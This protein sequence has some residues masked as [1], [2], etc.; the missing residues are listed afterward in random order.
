M[1]LFKNHSLQPLYFIFNI[2]ILIEVLIC[3]YA[4]FVELL[5]SSQLLVEAGKLA[6]YK[7]RVYK[8]YE[9]VT[10]KLITPLCCPYQYSRRSH[11]HRQ[12]SD[13][14]GGGRL[15]PLTSAN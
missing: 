6:S 15:H 7:I 12:Q 10:D 2:I 3:Y 8:Q 11:H 14:G 9:A 4:V 5:M 1:I 13:R